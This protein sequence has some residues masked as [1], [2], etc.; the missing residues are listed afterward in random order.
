M[1][2]ISLILFACAVIVG[3]A[4]AIIHISSSGVRTPPVPLVALHG[5]L[6]IGGLLLLALALQGPV[7]GL[8]TGT[9][10]F[11]AI[12]LGLLI[13]AALGGLV[14]LRAHMKRGRLPGA[15][16]GIHSLVAVAGFVMLLVYVLL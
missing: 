15:P 5:A 4:M 10:H 14:L 6:A 1:L 16:I 8:A 3:S 13:A 2:V 12:A 9:S 11:G 7:R